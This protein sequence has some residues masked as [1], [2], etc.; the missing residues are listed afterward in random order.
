MPNRPKPNEP[1]TLDL[2]QKICYAS[3]GMPNMTLGD[4]ARMAKLRASSVAGSIAL[5]FFIALFFT[6][7]ATAAFWY[8]LIYGGIAVS[9]AVAICDW[10]VERRRNA[11]ASA[12]GLWIVVAVVV[13]FLLVCIILPGL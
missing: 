11:K 5:G 7:L 6:S 3:N 2:S 13:L 9:S 1:E 10:R 8:Y 12:A 4:I